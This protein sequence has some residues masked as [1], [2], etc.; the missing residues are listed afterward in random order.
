MAGKNSGGRDYGY[1]GKGTTGYV[2]YKQD[3]D[4]NYGHEGGG[5][6]NGGCLGAF[7]GP[8]LFLALWAG[9][10][11]VAVYIMYVFLILIPDAIGSVFSSMFGMIVPFSVFQFL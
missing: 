5:G 1:Y 11:A 4:R 9:I 2:H 3:F 7:F 6:S 8:I 10:F